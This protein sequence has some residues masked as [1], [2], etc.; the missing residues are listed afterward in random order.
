MTAGSVLD[1]LVEALTRA[2]EYDPNAEERPAAVLW[3]D[4]SSQWEPVIN[5]V[6]DFVPLLVLGDYES[7][8]WRGPAYWVRCIVD[9]TLQIGR[10]HV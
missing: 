4:E 1:A 3:P 5:R 10:A 7:L 8:E 9:G 2:A 6:K